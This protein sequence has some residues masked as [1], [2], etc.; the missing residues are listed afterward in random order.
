MTGPI[1]IALSGGIDSLVAAYLLKMQAKEI[2]GLHFL[3]GFE[4]PDDSGPTR[5]KA[6]FQPL[7]IP[8]QVVDLKEQFRKTVV[9]YFAAAY[10]IGETPNPC[11]VCNP[12]IKFG[13]LLQKARQMGASCLATGH[14]ARVETDAS[15]RYRLLKGLDGGKDQ[16]YFLARLTQDQL[17]RACFPLGSWTKDRVRAL[18]AEK[19]LAPLAR[20]ESQDVCFVRDAGYADFLVETV[21]MIPR[22][23][24]IVDTQGRRVG[25][26][27]GL[28]R[29]TVGQRR[30]INCP[31]S[32]PYYVIRIEPRRNR[33]VV[34]FKEER[35][36]DSCRVRDINWIADVPDGPMAVDTRIR[37]RHQAV[38]STV[39][40]DQKG[41]ATVRFEAPQSSVTPGQGAVFYRGEEVIGGGWI[42]SADCSWLTADR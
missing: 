25:T 2:F 40:P 11:L 24:E 33:L 35:Y 6:L 8:V 31:A 39:T 36:A 17:A 26:H 20:S 16:S 13:V 37:Y 14:Y 4:K 34:G 9:D 30:G 27:E 18:A 32:R 41:G 22:P 7:D 5:I 23:G 28:H 38:P 21:G 29:F 12:T 3:T 10:Q 1:A 42:Q 19:G 15:A